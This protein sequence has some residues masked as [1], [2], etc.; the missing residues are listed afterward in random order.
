MILYQKNGTSW[1]SFW[2]FFLADQV[3]QLFVNKMVES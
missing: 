1:F 2:V 3:G